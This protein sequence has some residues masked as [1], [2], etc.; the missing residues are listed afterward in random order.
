MNKEE[1]AE[2]IY[3]ILKEKLDIAPLDEISELIVH[4]LEQ[5]GVLIGD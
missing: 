2:H 1:I 3:F 5:L 4:E